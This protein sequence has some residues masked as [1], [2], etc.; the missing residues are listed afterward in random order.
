MAFEDGIHGRR[1]QSVFDGIPFRA[2]YMLLRAQVMEGRSHILKSG[3]G[4][5]DYFLLSV[6]TKESILYAIRF[7]W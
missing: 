3:Q 2:I 7:D 6:T 1:F 4:Q 5:N